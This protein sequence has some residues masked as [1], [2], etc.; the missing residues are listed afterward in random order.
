MGSRIMGG[1]GLQGRF[2][3]KLQC[4]RDI[5]VQ[6][7][8]KTQQGIGKKITYSHYIHVIYK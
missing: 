5:L 2:E 1:G 8:S 3:G 4:G 7:T 6:L